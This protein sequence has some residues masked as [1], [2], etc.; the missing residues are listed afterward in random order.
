MKKKIY[1]MIYDLGSAHRS[2][3]NSLREVI[4]QQNL[5]WEVHIVDFFKEIIGNTRPHYVFN[6]L[7]LQKKWA[8]IINEPI[9]TPLFKLEIRLQHS[10]W[11]KLL[12]KYWQEHQPDM[13]VSILPFVN[14][15]LYQSLKEAL[16]KVPFITLPTDAIDYPQ[17]FWYEKQHEFA[18]CLSP[19]AVEQVKKL[20][21]Q[22]ES[23][24]STSG[25]VIN[26]R[27]YQPITADRSLERKRLGLDPNLPTG[28]IFFGGQG[29][30]KMLQ[31]ADFLTKSD[32]K[33]QLIFICGRN[34]QL[35]EKLRSQQYRFPTVVEGFTK[36]IPYYMHLSDFLV[37][38]PG[39]G[40]I[41][42]AVKM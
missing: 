39:A 16:P 6:N 41:N 23:I 8:R 20:G 33:I 11:L 30:D 38:K 12:K 34:Q 7:V 36:E 4:E 14:K 19:K 28:L 21:Y 24:F 10:R 1:L 42:E 3:A 22:E 29:S 5:A 27:F 13:V 15:V 9:L 32:L 26:P 18:I 31:I 35:A 17:H 37:G 40:C 2:T 25:V